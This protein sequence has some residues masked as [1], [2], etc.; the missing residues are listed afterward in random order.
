MHDGDD[1]DWE[2]GDLETAI[3]NMEVK[4][5]E[6]T[7]KAKPEVDDEVV[8][9][10]P[11]HKTGA[12]P[13]VKAVKLPTRA[14][15]VSTSVPRTPTVVSIPVSHSKPPI[16]AIRSASVNSNTNH[17]N[18]TN[19]GGVHGSSHVHIH[20][21]SHINS[22]STD[23]QEGQHFVAGKGA[24]AP[25]IRIPIRTT[26]EPLDSA[27]LSALDS[28]RNRMQ[29]LESEQTLLHYVQDKTLH[30]SGKCEC[31]YI[32]ML[33]VMQCSVMQCSEMEC[34][35]VTDTIPFHSMCS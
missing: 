7:E 21:S 25:Q 6:E 28:H 12:N 19:S 27:L 11:N 31:E 29:L 15:T 24:A 16:I 20:H 5:V 4:A 9:T 13:I 34:S 3:Q 30:Y 1:D 26:V 35:V 22:S 10:K 2:S 33:R 17:S 18:Q 14:P 32:C 23:R 8:I